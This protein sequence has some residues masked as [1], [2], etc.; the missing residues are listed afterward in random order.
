MG[1]SSNVHLNSHRNLVPSLSLSITNGHRGSWTR[2]SSLVK[3]V[4][5]G[6]GSALELCFRAME[7]QPRLDWLSK[8]I[9]S[10]CANIC[11]Y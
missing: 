5:L 2:G 8:C 1:F 7:W 9:R 3:S 4:V 6:K 10:R 11:T